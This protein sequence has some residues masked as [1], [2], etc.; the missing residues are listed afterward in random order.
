[1][2]ATS[3][4]HS[5]NGVPFGFVPIAFR[6]TATSPPVV[7]F[8]RRGGGRIGIQKNIFFLIDISAP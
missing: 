7:A 5:N 2:P 8:G 3:R 4:Q 6:R 1:M